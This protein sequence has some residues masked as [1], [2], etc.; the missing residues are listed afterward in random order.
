MK[1][2]SSNN[3]KG[4]DFFNT[5]KPFKIILIILLI[6]LMVALFPLKVL[7][8]K[9]FRTEKYLELWRV[10]EEE[11]FTIKYTHSVEK[12]PVTEKYKV[13]EDEIILLETT[14]KSYGAGLPATTEYDFELIDDGFRIYNINKKYR[15][16]IYR[17]GAEIANHEIIIGDKTYEFLDFSKKRAG[18]RFST[19]R[20]S[21]LNYIIKTIIL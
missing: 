16:V 5:L 6:F 11:E 10:K 4:I 14:F 3:I 20:I 12:S 17:T 2:E 8:A 15:D 7:V 1:K 19:E 13:Y 21:L 18:V 9:D